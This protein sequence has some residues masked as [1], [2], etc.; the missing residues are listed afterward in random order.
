MARR[1]LAVALAWLVAGTACAD[2]DVPRN[3]FDDPFFQIANGIPKCP[4]P[5]GPFLTES[6]MKAESHARAER[7]TS[8]WLSRELATALERRLTD[9]P[10]VE[11]VIV[12]V[13][14][15]AEGRPPYRLVPMSGR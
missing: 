9:V 11:R 8:C 1:A 2:G 14:T 6:E 13:M 5:L 4:R 10:H 15:D 7:G 3:W 12:N